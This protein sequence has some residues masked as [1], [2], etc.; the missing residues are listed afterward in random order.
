MTAMTGPVS[1]IRVGRQTDRLSKETTPDNHSY[2]LSHEAENLPTKELNLKDTQRESPM[3]HQHG[4][5][6]EIDTPPPSLP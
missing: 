5:Y 2:L 6:A 1:K 4:Q 3:H